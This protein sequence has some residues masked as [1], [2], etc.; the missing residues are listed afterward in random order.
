[1]GN[2]QLAH[3]VGESILCCD[4]WR[5]GSSKMTLESTCYNALLVMSCEKRYSIQ[6]SLLKALFSPAAVAENGMG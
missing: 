1:V 6:I 2:V 3:A 5:L 4:G